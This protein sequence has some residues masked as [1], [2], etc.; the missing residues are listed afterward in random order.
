MDLA[1]SSNETV[2][3][4]SA[5]LPRRAAL[6]GGCVLFLLLAVAAAAG[7]PAW[8]QWNWRN[9]PLERLEE[10]ARQR[11]EQIDLYR[12]LTLRRLNQG[13]AARAALHARWVAQAEPQDPSSWVLYGRALL[14]LG[15]LDASQAA[16]ERALQLDPS[17][18]EAHLHLASLF[19]QR[20]SSHGAVTHLQ[21][22]TAARPRDAAGWKLMSE[23]FL[24]LEEPGNARSAAD[25]GLAL[26]PRDLDLLYLSGRS[27]QLLGELEPARA[28]LNAALEQ[29]P[30]HPGASIAL[31]LVLQSSGA[32]ADRNEAVR[33][34]SHAAEAHPALP[35]IQYEL[36]QALN[37]AG[38]SRGALRAWQAG[39]K[40][41]PN[42]PRIHQALSLL[43]FRLGRPEE[44]K[45]HQARHRQILK[46]AAA[47]PPDKS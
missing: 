43:L 25:R 32:A 40:A 31:A 28:R 22:Y 11:P 47:A 12:H 10:E 20:G 21:K 24:E 38:D 29:Q 8:Q 33:L 46:G 15:Q 9:Q 37:D 18:A 39:L 13:E 42:H 44:A 4:A 7:W 41:D 36:G 17:R 2:R 27:A 5:R 34:L 6:A 26:A 30:A 14:A 23:Q 1:G 16:L 35:G 19:A 3:A 45:R